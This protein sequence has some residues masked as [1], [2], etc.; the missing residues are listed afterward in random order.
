MRVLVGILFSSILLLILLTF[1]CSHSPSTAVVTLAATP[2][3][4][5]HLLPF[6][7]KDPVVSY[8]PTLRPT[9][10]STSTPTVTNAPTNTPTPT[11]TPT[12]TP[13]ATVTS[14]PT[15][16]ATPLPGL[17]GVEGADVGND[18]VRALVVDAGAQWVRVGMSWAGVEPA[19]I[20]L[21]DPTNGNWPDGFFT[22]LADEGLSPVVLI[23]IS[24][25]WAVE[26][27][28]SY[29]CGPIDEGDLDDFGE[30]VRAAVARYDGDGDYDNDGHIDGSAL[31][32]V[33][34]WEF[35]NEAEGVGP[36][37]AEYGGCWGGEYWNSSVDKDDD[38]DNDG[39]ADPEEYARMLSYAYPALKDANPEAQLLFGAVAYDR[40][41]SVTWFNLDFTDQVLDA[42]PSYPGA[43]FDVM[44]FHAYSNPA[45]ACNW[46]PPNILGKAIGQG[47]HNAWYDKD[48]MMGRPSV[49]GLLTD[50]ELDKPLVCSELGRG[51]SGSQTD[52]DP[53]E[54]NEGQSRHVVR[55]FTRAMRL[56]PDT[57][58]VAIWF[59]VVDNADDPKPFGLLD[60]DPEL[61]R[62]SSWYAYYTLTNELAGAQYSGLLSGTGVE[63]Y[64]FAMPGGSEKTVVWVPPK[65]PTKKA[66]PPGDPTPRGFAVGVGERLR[67]VRMY[68]VSPG[69][70][71]WAWEE[72]LIEDGGAGDL[73]GS[74]NGQ[75]QI[76]INSNPQFVEPVPLS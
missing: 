41:Y 32:E 37:G 45:L 48:Y 1:V 7:A 55:G 9:P 12:N 75:V 25:S 17:F 20:D 52:V 39:L 56:W 47:V 15:G 64:V 16:T 31:P 53:P 11:H 57:M 71:E 24:P 28:L 40:S 13:T 10:T 36:K 46:D 72:V 35:W 54:T 23:F 2:T 73:D 4:A 8:T 27:M 61:H 50:H 67:V 60:P 66:M 65:E 6:V 68:E 51:S 74:A 58:K 43:D 62:K 42:L 30:F 69:S 76:M 22:T 3:M 44:N 63:G 70:D 18:T 19:N 59:R 26:G 21:T 14:T 34:Y 29:T 49:Q 33:L 38:W 5:P